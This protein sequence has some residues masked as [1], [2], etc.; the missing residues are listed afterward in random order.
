MACPPGGAGAPADRGGGLQGGAGHPGFQEEAA[1]QAAL[2]GA[3]PRGRPG[4]FSSYV[5]TGKSY[6]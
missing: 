2:D 5:A 6:R 1:A 4:L 3:S